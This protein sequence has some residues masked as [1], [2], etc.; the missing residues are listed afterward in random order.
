MIKKLV[1]VCLILSLAFAQ[2]TETGQ[3]DPALQK[4]YNLAAA[5]IAIVALTCVLSTIANLVP[6]CRK[7][8]YVQAA[9]NQA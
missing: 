2:T 5:V 6:L 3:T 1:L 4:T 8:Q 9:K 7:D